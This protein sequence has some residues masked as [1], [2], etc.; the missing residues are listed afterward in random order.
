MI[1]GEKVDMACRNC[2]IKAWEPEQKIVWMAEGRVRASKGKA[3]VMQGA[4]L[5]GTVQY[6]LRHE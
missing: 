6:K 1:K 4:T 3:K 2:L 5:D